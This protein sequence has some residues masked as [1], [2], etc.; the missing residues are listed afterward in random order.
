MRHN[1]HWIDEI[2]EAKTLNQS[3]I[4][5]E[6]KKFDIEFKNV[7]FTYP[8][9]KNAAI[10]N[11]SVSIL[12]GKT[13]ALVGP[14]GGGKTTLASLVPR[15]WDVDEGSVLIGGVDVKNIEEKELMN[16]V[17]FV[18]Q[19]NKL[20]K[21]SLLENIRIGNPKASREEILK[22]AHLAQCDDIL[23]KMPQG[24]DTIVGTE[25]VYLSG[26]EKQRIS[27]A[28][29]ILKN[30]PIVVLD[31]ATAFTD[32][33]NEYKLQKAFVSLVKNKT[34]IMIAHRLS[35]IKDVDCILVL[36]E[37]KIAEKGNHK[38]LLNKKGLYSEMWNEYQNSISWKV[39][40]E[41]AHA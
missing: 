2:I 13:Y 33:E 14:S 12:E 23:E 11:V 35:S 36:K 25:G 26:G 22:A 30:A 24:L 1:D 41:K 7:T 5:N 18:F 6:I 10:S 28:R 9:N 31:E 17:A 3:N 39:G 15:F 20:F 8:E 38:E 27:L 4:K 32:P 34:V 40:K 19:N 16:K 21:T 37:G 29:A